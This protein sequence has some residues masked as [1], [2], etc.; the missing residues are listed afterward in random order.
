MVNVKPPTGTFGNDYVAG[1]GGHDEL[2]GQGGD[3][4]VE[5]GWGSDAVIG[6]LGKVT[7][8]LLGAGPA[9]PC[10]SLPRRSPRRS[11]S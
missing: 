9:T 10:A 7:T 3:D 11:R 5:G 1:N 4:A 6:D 2:Y 8:D